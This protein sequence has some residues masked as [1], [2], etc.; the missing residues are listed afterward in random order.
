M[1]L[2]LGAMTGLLALAIGVGVAG[3]Q[4]R[5]R[6]MPPGAAAP[7]RIEELPARRPA[8]PTPV[9]AGD[10]GCVSTITHTVRMGPANRVTLGYIRVHAPE[11]IAAM[12]QLV[13]QKK[14]PAGALND[15]GS[16]ELVRQV[17]ATDWSQ[18]L[19]AAQTPAATASVTASSLHEREAPP[20]AAGAPA[21]ASMDPRRYE[22]SARLDEPTR[23]AG[24]AR[25][26]A[27]MATASMLNQIAQLDI[28]PGRIDM[29]SV[30]VGQRRRAGFRVI[31]FIDGT[32]SVRAAL[33]S[34]VHVFSVAPH[35]S[36]LEPGLIRAE[37]RPARQAEQAIA[38]GLDLKAGQSADVLVEFTPR[39]QD[40]FDGSSKAYE[41]S[42]TVSVT[43]GAAPPEASPPT[44]TAYRVRPGDSRLGALDIAE[45][46]V[47]LRAT[48][49]GRLYGIGVAMDAPRVYAEARATFAVYFDWFNNGVAG[50][51]TL[52]VDQASLPAGVTVSGP[53]S[54]SI[55]L[56]QGEEKQWA[57]LTF[58]GPQVDPP[59]T[60][61]WDL[62]PAEQ[63][64]KITFSL[65]Q[66]S[67]QGGQTTR[68]A[69]PVH[70][71]GISTWYN[72]EEWSIFPK[73]ADV[74]HHYYVRL[75][76]DGS[77]SSFITVGASDYHNNQSCQKYFDHT[78]VGVDPFNIFSNA[79][80]F[81][82][83]NF[84]IKT[85]YN[86]GESGWLRTN[87]DDTVSWFNVSSSV[88]CEHAITD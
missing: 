85:Y 59:P 9:D 38:R 51:A 57:Y 42:L 46:K 27:S 71:G 68:Y 50:D 3:A 84:G 12:A 8:P 63:E 83:G 86:V 32:L 15:L 76:T 47:D 2:V 48:V 40:G 35:A 1:R 11:V 53:A 21:G 17:I 72:F 33:G 28:S 64:P 23:G 30:L 80:T 87:Y 13:R 24:E 37:A 36:E 62:T 26:P 6:R 18:V 56:D 60:N 58:S 25:L 44:A 10:G 67:A 16:P 66:S 69:V 31:S 61:S 79:S 52:A 54:A 34:F 4:V 14:L 65:S 39:L 55:H 74:Y 22:G 5:T 7:S 75:S 77:Y 43:P 88:D 78:T 20:C 70:I 73:R 29:G 19:P 45:R 41:T 49:S 81:H 82:N